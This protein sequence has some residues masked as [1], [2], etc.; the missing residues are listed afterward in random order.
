MVTISSGSRPLPTLSSC[1]GMSPSL[2]LIDS[3]VSVTLKAQKMMMEAV[4]SRGLC[5]S[6][7][8]STVLSHSF[9]YWRHCSAKVSWTGLKRRTS[10]HKLL[11]AG[12]ELCD[13]L[14]TL[15]TRLDCFFWDFYQHILIL[16]NGFHYIFIY[17]WN[18]IYM[19]HIISVCVFIF[20]C[21]YPL[22]PFLITLTPA[23]W[24]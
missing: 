21:I 4:V 11:R 3:W 19:Y 13:T 20:D 16:H 1:D 17:I 14:A 18:M 15:V 22:S 8:I 10:F 24:V 6:T 2:L 23:V 9:A 12:I 7:L 5:S